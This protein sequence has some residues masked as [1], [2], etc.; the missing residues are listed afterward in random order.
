MDS[1]YLK[2]Q[3]IITRKQQEKE[4]KKNRKT[5]RVTKCYLVQVLDAEGNEL[6]CEYAFV[7]SKKEAECRGKEMID[8]LND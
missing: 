7:D 5:I 4:A 8:Y 3:A 6:Q 1:Q 2:S